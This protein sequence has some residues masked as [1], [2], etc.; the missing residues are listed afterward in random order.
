MIKLIWKKK[1]EAK[2]IRKM[3]R[4]LEQLSLEDLEMEID[5]IELKAMDMMELEEPNDTVDMMYEDTL[6]LGLEQ[7]GVKSMPMLTMGEENKTFTSILNFYHPQTPIYLGGG[8][9]QLMV[10]LGDECGKRKR[11]S[12]E[13]LRRNKRRRGFSAMD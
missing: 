11:E 6:E 12:L 13:G 3:Y 10:G 4:M 9:N 8:V 1:L 2:N 5:D 7:D